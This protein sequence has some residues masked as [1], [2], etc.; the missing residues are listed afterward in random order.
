MGLTCDTRV[1]NTLQTAKLISTESGWWLKKMAWLW[2]CWLLKGCWLELRR[3]HVSTLCTQPTAISATY[4]K[5]K[6][7]PV[8][9]MKVYEGS[10]SK[11]PIIL[12]LVI[13]WRVS[14]HFHSPVALPPGK[15][16]GYLLG[17]RKVGPQ[18]WY[19]RFGE[20]LASSKGSCV[21][22]VCANKNCLR[23]LDVC[24]IH[25]SPPTVAKL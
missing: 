19:R 21:W 17:R 7:V 16:P 5:G 25:S 4:S 11:T 6:G 24:Q 8:H 14:G 20:W 22:K 3:S 23:T 18:G 12:N 13:S 9:A 15:E 2:D 1:A 10:R